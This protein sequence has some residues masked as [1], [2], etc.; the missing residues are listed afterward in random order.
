MRAIVCSL[1]VVVGSAVPAMAD[2]HRQLGAHV[3]G[4]GTLDVAVEG[5]HINLALEAPGADI[6]GFE[7]EAASEADKAAL[8]AAEARLA[9]PLALFRLP[10]ASGCALDRADVKLEAEDHDDDH[11]HAGHDDHDHDAHDH[12]GPGEHHHA[13][14]HADYALTCKDT[15]ALTAIGF[16]YFK[17]FAGAQSLTVNVAAAK[18]QASYEVGRDHPQLDLKGTM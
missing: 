6:V 4:H 1:V 2:E 11:D 15:G 14:F 3:H 7:H 13:A 12:D 8:K 18:G 9:D 17:A 5:N 16:D 10:A